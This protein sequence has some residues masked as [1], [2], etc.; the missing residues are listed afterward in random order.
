MGNI[1]Q[2]ITHGGILKAVR[3]LL[4]TSKTVTEPGLYAADAKSV[5]DLQDEIDELTTNKASFIDTS[6]AVAHSITGTSTITISKDG[7]LVGNLATYN[8]GNVRIS[9]GN[10]DVGY[11]QSSLNTWIYVPVCI[12]VKKGQILK[13]SASSTAYCSVGLSVIPG[14]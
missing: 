6:A 10:K 3:S 8:G 14:L 1:I 5:K 4:T 9:L 2:R 11:T 12:P 7:F 13:V